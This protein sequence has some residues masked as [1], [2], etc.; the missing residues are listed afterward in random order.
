[1]TFITFPRK[2]SFILRFQSD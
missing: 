1:M 2:S